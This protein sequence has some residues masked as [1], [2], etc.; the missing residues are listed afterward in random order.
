[1]KAKDLFERW[2]LPVFRY[3]RRLTGDRVLAEELCQDVFTR[4]V[5]SLER[6]QPAGREQ[7]WVFSIALNVFRN[8]RRDHARR[9]Q[10]EPM[11]ANELAGSGHNLALALDLD[12]AL[13]RLPE[14]DRESFLLREMGGLGYAEISDLLDVTPDAV[15]SRIHRAR[16]ALREELKPVARRSYPRM[17]TEGNPHE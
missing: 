5:Q 12:Q 8:Q 6:Y 14:S 13:A 2:H 4:V 16:K 10:P 9:L 15:R 17:V 1:M 7:A 3:L 11:P